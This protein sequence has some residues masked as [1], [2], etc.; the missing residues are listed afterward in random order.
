[1]EYRENVGNRTD[2][3]KWHEGD[4]H[5]M[6]CEDVGEGAMIVRSFGLPLTEITDCV[7]LERRV[8]RPLLEEVGS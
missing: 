5:E 2:D 3:G 4:A 8:V 6:Y 7:A 1:M